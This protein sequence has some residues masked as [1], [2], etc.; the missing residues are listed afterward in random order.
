MYLVKIGEA[1][2]RVLDR[3]D[4]KILTSK[5]LDMECT[6]RVTTKKVEEGEQEGEEDD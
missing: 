1:Q 4:A 6:E 5:L 3:E 2:I